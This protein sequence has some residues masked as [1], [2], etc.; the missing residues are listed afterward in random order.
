MSQFSQATRLLGRREALR[1][2]GIGVIGATSAAV[3]GACG[4]DTSTGPGSTVAAQSLAAFLRGS[5][6]ISF[7]LDAERSP[8][9][10]T[11][12]DG[13]WSADYRDG[14][15]GTW[16]YA[17]GSLQIVNWTGDNSVGTATG[18]PEQVTEGSVPSTLPWTW[19]GTADSSTDDD[20]SFGL[21]WDQRSS[22]MTITAT[23]ANGQP[24]V[25][26]AKRS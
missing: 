3:L 1:C 23:D 10:V 5:W 19:K 2:F 8:F 22:T 12:K 24:L 25:I 20:L 11:V 9:T 26:E 13:A 21:A 14:E 7:P 18:V 15:E 6:A 4:K 16:K 17:G